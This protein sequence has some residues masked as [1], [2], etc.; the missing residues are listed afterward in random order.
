MPRESVEYSVKLR[1]ADHQGMVERIRNEIQEL[2][3]KAKRRRWGPQR[4]ERKIKDYFDRLQSEIDQ[5][6][7][8]TSENRSDSEYTSSYI[9]ADS[10]PGPASSPS[11]SYVTAGS[12]SS[13]SSNYVT[14][15]S[16]S[17]PSSIYF[18][19]G[20]GSVSDSSSSSEYFTADP[21]SSSG[22]GCNPTKIIIANVPKV[23]YV[24]CDD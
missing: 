21:C 11:S 6:S 13:P 15:G 3:E 7:E 12:A 23:I 2:L 24:N 22:S 14:A 17:S 8:G 9:T 19:A 10:G 1:G 16:E 5:R 4:L 18:T 20:S